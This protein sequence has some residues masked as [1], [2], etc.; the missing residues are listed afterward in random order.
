MDAEHVEYIKQIALFSLEL[1][2][3]ADEISWYADAPF[4]DWITLDGPNPMDYGDTDTW[5]LPTMN[6]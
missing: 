3:I 5:L 2:S 1:G 6:S 4:E